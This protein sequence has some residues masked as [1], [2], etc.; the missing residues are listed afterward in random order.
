MHIRRVESFARVTLPEVT[1]LHGGGVTVYM[2]VVL[3][4]VLTVHG[5]GT[6][7]NACLYGLL[8]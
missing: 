1:F 3:V 8:S 7:Q 4:L 6:L 2:V 5:V